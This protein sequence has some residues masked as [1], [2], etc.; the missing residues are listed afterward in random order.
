[1]CPSVWALSASKGFEDESFNSLELK[2]CRA[3]SQGVGGLEG[4]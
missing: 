2:A 3:D 4:R 1:M